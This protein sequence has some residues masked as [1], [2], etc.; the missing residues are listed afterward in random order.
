MGKVAEACE[1]DGMTFS[2]FARVHGLL[3][4][5]LEQGKWV[6]VPTEDHPRK[7]NGRYKWLGDIGWVQNWAT[8]SVP[9]MW[10]G[11]DARPMDIAKVIRESDRERKEQA[12]K[13][14]KKAAWILHQSE[15]A[16]HPYLEHKGF[17]EGRGH[18]WQKDGQRFL[19]VPMRAGN[20]VGCQLIN[21]EGQKK[22]LFGQQTKGA[23][24]TVDAKGLHILC[25]GYATGL[26]IRAAMRAL[27]IR[28]T[29]HVCFSAWNME[30]VSRR[31][32]QGVVIAD[33]DVN[34]VGE[35]AAR[36]TGKPYWLSGTVG[37]DFNDLHVKSGL[38]HASAD[39]KRWFD[40]VGLA[41]G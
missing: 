4:S 32:P 17:P 3:V 24:F 35:Q 9:M 10:K 23:S 16:P 39:L 1:A 19:V 21:E 30:T 15:L 13:A 27:R 5:N 25:E 37:E 18:V 6:A 38:A 22:F 26:S 31:I 20:L 33:R 11:Q 34:G 41:D 40:S 28:Y 2:D 12:E 14:A 29:I 7:R 8:M 36:K